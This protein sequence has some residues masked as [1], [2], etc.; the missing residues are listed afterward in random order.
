MTH[1]QFLEK[2]LTKKELNRFLK[3]LEEQSPEDVYNILHGDFKYYSLAGAFI[4]AN[5]RKGIEYWYRLLEITETKKTQ[6]I[7]N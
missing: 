6:I 7:N 4:F 5:S 2:V 1:Y 3:E